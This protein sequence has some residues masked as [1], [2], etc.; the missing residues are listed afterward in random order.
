MEIL[1]ILVQVTLTL[2]FLSTLIF[3]SKQLIS[4][5]TGTSIKVEGGKLRFPD[6]TICTLFY[7]PDA[8]E[9]RITPT[10]GHKFSDLEKLMTSMK[11][12]IKDIIIIDLDNT[13]KTYVR[14]EYTYFIAVLFFQRLFRKLIISDFP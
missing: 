11:E 3:Y 1:E 8:N 10:S 6:F 13:N 2:T 4:A 14:F 7:K 9:I 5:E 12:L